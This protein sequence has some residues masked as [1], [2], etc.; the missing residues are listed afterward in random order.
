MDATPW[1]IVSAIHHNWAS[2]RERRTGR[3]R[4]EAKKRWHI[5]THHHNWAGIDPL[6]CAEFCNPTLHTTKVIEPHCELFS[7]IQYDFTSKSLVFN[8]VWSEEK[9]ETYFF[10][11]L[12]LLF[13]VYFIFRSGW[14]IADKC[15]KQQDWK[16][17]LVNSFSALIFISSFE[18]RQTTLRVYNPYKLN[19]N[20]QTT[21]EELRLHLLLFLLLL[22]AWCYLFKDMFIETIG[23]S[24][25]KTRKAGISFQRLGTWKNYL[26]REYLQSKHIQGFAKECFIQTKLL[27]SPPPWAFNNRLFW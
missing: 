12:L 15:L 18:L 7:H 27:S 25:S 14:K 8:C 23:V 2:V 17:N 4:A 9:R 20:T 24:A 19:I 1:Q 11:L 21:L 26:Q 22:C 13:C 10:I 5:I 3:N 6:I 16:K